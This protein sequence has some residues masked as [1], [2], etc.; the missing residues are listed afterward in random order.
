MRARIGQY[1]NPGGAFRL[2]V[3]PGLARPSERAKSVA[4]ID[5]DRLRRQGFSFVVFD[6]VS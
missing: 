6:K 4:H 1:F 5:F 2:L 3:S